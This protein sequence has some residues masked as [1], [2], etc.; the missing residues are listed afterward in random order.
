MIRSSLLQLLST[1]L[2][3]L[4]A[5]L[6][7][8]CA[9]LYDRV[10]SGRDPSAAQTMLFHALDH[11]ALPPRSIAPTPNKDSHVDAAI[12]SMQK[13]AEDQ[14]LVFDGSRATQGIVIVGRMGS[15][16]P[17]ILAVAVY[18]VGNRIAME[19]VS[20]EKAPDISAAAR[21]RKQFMGTLSRP[22]TGTK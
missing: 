10:P 16:G 12:H 7:S 20:R 14:G 6:P 21:M 1:A 17:M 2:V 22:P 13:V 15:A 4:A 19:D 9:L 8:G 5:L 3:G 11:Y 18:S